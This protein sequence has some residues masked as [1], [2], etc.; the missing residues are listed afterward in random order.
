MNTPID[1]SKE[2]WINLNERIITVETELH[3]LINNHIKHLADDI[4]YIKEKMN[5]KRPS[6]SVSVIITFLCSLS[7]AL[8][9][10]VVCA[11]VN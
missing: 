8:I 2:D 10:A 9:T 7:V 1:I 6:W 3:S 4:T 5:G 11:S